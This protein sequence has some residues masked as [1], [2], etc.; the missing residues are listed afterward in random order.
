[1]AD[2]ENTTV[3]IVDIA[4]MAGV[5]VATVDRVIHNRGKV[6]E[7]NLARINEVLRKV[8]YRPNLIAR[9]LASGR[10]YT[11]AVVMP[12][13]RRANTGPTSTPGSS[14]P[15]P[16]PGVTTFRSANSSS[17]STTAHRSKNCLQNSAT[18]R[19]TAR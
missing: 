5:S 16:R 7:E 1:M 15:R 4:R 9:S 10:Q 18:K 12:A 13:S 8:N 11:L 2:N 3:R 19:S 14:A 6:S 17:T